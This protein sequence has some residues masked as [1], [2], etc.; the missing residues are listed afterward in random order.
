M[1]DMAMRRGEKEIEDREEIEEIIGRALVCRLGMVD[2][3]RPYVVPLSFGYEG[4]CLYLHSA[5]AGRKI[6]VLRRSPEVCFEMDVDCEV[7]R[8]EQACQWGMRFR[9]IIGF[10][11]VEFLEDAAEKRKGLEVIMA[12]YAESGERFSFADREVERTVVIRVE[13]ENMS[14]KKSGYD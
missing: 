4:G 10:G 9:S 13:I 6:E 3:G 8:A 5:S 14:G 11:R 7:A 1:G 2:E 12:H